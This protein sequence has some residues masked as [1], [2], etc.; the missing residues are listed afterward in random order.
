M[1]DAIYSEELCTPDKLTDKIFHEFDRDKDGV[2]SFEEFCS[3]A[4]KDPFLIH[5]LECDPDAHKPDHDDKET[6]PGTGE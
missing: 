4:S 2:L 1:T 3:T 5:L 6:H